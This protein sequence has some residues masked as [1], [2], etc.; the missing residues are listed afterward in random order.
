MHGS[1]YLLLMDLPQ[2]RRRRRWLKFLVCPCREIFS[3]F[4]SFFFIKWDLVSH[5]SRSGWLAFYRWAASK[6]RICRRAEDERERER[7]R[8]RTS[9]GGKAIRATRDDLRQITLLME[10]IS[11]AMICQLYARDAPKKEEEDYGRRKHSDDQKLAALSPP[12]PHTQRHV[13]PDWYMTIDG[14]FCDG[15]WQSIGRTRSLSTII[16]YRIALFSAPVLDLFYSIL[17]APAAET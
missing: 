13:R 9:D 8:E 10:V 3:F 14:P 16:T 11:S 4:L 5:P 1:N 17:A 15:I 6:V 2:P 12:P 7:E